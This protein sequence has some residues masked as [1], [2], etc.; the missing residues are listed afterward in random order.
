MLTIRPEQSAM[1]VQAAVDR[2]AG[3]MVAHFREHLPEPFAALGEEGVREAV[4]Y[5]IGQARSYRIESEAGVRVFIQLMFVLGP[6]FDTD[7]RLPWA[8]RC[9]TGEGDERARVGRLLIA[10]GDHVLER[11]APAGG[12]G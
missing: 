12:V 6:G 3:E 1:F 8:A 10:A 2:F 5:G 9:L 4:R 7:P 11:G